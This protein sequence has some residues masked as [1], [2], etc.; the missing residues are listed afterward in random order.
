M[1]QLY[2][3]D[4]LKGPIMA[5]Y[6]RIGSIP[7]LY[8]KPQGDLDLHALHAHGYYN[9]YVYSKFETCKM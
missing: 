2:G 8:L 4:L 1:N 6:R 3:P 5:S 7:P 9:G